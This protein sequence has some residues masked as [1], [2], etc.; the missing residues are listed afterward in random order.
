MFYSNSLLS[1]A[2]MHVLQADIDYLCFEISFLWIFFFM[3]KNLGAQRASF[4]TAKTGEP[5]D[6]YKRFCFPKSQ[7]FLFCKAAP[8][9][10]RHSSGPVFSAPV[11]FGGKRNRYKYI[12]CYAVI[13]YFISNTIIM[14]VLL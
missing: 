7:R 1:L 6:Y 11:D 5:T 10:C 12:A 13:K 2:F 8:C 9:I 4:S 3:V 14:C